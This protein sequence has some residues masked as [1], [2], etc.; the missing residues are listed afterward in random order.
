[1]LRLKIG[2]EIHFRVIQDG[3][4]RHSEDL[5][6]VSAYKLLDVSSQCF[7]IIC[8]TK[9]PCKNFV[10]KATYIKIQDGGHRHLE[11]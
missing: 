9:L 2:S 1:M 6:S 4:G 3:G 8:R 11:S 7:V 10:K 5:K